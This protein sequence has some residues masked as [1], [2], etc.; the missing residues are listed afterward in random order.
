MASTA[1]NLSGDPTPVTGGIPLPANMTSQA[2]NDD[3][4]PADDL[5]RQAYWLR[6]LH[7]SAV[8]VEFRNSDL[9]AMDDETKR[10]LIRAIQQALG[11]APLKG[12]TL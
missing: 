7:P 10:L 5:G 12:E 6:K 4:A 2:M 1:S 3:A 8:P 11:I 9:T